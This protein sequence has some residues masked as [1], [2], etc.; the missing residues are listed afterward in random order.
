MDNSTRNNT[1]VF[2]GVDI[3][4]GMMVCPKCEERQLIN[5]TTKKKR[6]FGD[7]F[8]QKLLDRL[9]GKKR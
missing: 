1:C 3:P 6:L 7:S 2:C 8:N 9:T 5:S 4:E